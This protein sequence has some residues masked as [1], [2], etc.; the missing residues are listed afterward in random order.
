MTADAVGMSPW[1]SD[2]GV[3]TVGTSTNIYVF[4]GSLW[5]PKTRKVF[6]GTLWK[7]QLV[8]KL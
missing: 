7:D 5:V 8:Q 3:F 4:D 2:T 1:S 6:D